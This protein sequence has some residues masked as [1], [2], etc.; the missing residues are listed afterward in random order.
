MSDNTAQDLELDENEQ[1]KVRK[2]KLADI[3][4]RGQ[5]YPNDFKR[6]HLAADLHAAYGDID[7]EPLAEKNVKVAIAGR[8]MTRRIMG[9][10]SFATLQDLSGRIQIYVSRDDLAEGFYNEQ[11][12]K[13][14]IGDIVGGEGVLFKTKTGELSVRVSQLKLLTKALRPLPDKWHGLADVEQRYRHR[15]I[16]LIVNETTRDIFKIRSGTL[17]AIRE[18]YTDRG[19]VEVETPMLQTLAGGAAAKPFNTHHNA[20]DLPMSLRIAPELF[21]KR[22]VVGGLEKVYEINRNFRNEGLSTRHNPE[23]T[24]LESYEAYTDYQD[25]MNL[26]EDLL[27]HVVK[28]VLTDTNVAYQ[29]DT[30]DFNNPFQRMTVLEAI[31]HFCDDVSEADLNDMSKAKAYAEKLGIKIEP[32]YGLGKIQIEI[33]EKT[34]EHRLMAPTFITEYPA[35]VSPLARRN[36]A[37]PFITER[38]ELFIGG[39]ELANGFSELNDPAIQE[40]VFRAQMEN[41]RCG[42]DEAM[43]F[44]ADYIMALEH[45]LPPTAGLGIGIDRLVMLLT[46]SPSIRDVILFPHMKPA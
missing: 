11:F 14:D 15:Y 19:F 17:T 28:R 34:A 39:R 8:I 2:E 25:A 44:D 20:L 42:D 31:C 36:E 37:N 30:Y 18:F 6:E 40:Q 1:I 12:K 24:M 16:D 29:G 41:K 10:A 26:I 9:K 3:C 46:D 21:L 27:R 38:F 13:W 43:P 33:F 7:K 35:E 5:A 45:G 4:A 22:L 32:N 23:F